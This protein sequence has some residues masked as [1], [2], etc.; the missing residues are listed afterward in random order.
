MKEMF[1]QKLIS[2]DFDLLFTFLIGFKCLEGF[3][4]NEKEI[5]DLFKLIGKL[6]HVQCRIIVRKPYVSYVF[7]KLNFFGITQYITI[8]EDS[9]SY[10]VS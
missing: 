4:V 7:I 5:K 10:I 9:R 1:N 3:H 6:A 8:L 2:V